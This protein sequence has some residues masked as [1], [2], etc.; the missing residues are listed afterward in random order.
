MSCVD[1]VC[2]V[3]DIFCSST[4]D[5]MHKL[6]TQRSTQNGLH[7]RG[8]IPTREGVCTCDLGIAPRYK[9]GP[10]LDTYS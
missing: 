6:Q 9:T 4:T 2:R 3:S 8:R 7:I 1:C 10:R 5:Q